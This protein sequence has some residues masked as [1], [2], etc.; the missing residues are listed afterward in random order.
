M[1]S[2][3]ISKPTCQKANVFH[4]E[5]CQK[6]WDRY[7]SGFTL[8]EIL[9]G[10]MIM[11]VVS[12]GVG[13]LA[14]EAVNQSSA[15]SN[16]VRDI[17]EAQKIS[18]SL[19]QLLTSAACVSGPAQI[20]GG[21]VGW[22]IP[23]VYDQDCGGD[24]SQIVVPLPGTSTPSPVGNTSFYLFSPEEIPV[25]TGTVP[26]SPALNIYTEFYVSTKAELV[27]GSNLVYVTVQNLQNGA[28]TFLGSDLRSIS[29]SYVPYSNIVSFS[30]KCSAGGSPIPN[31]GAI[32]GSIE[33]D[34]SMGSSASDKTGT[35]Y[36]SCIFLPGSI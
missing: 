6:V 17:S 30:N 21:G 16:R 2:S 24:P 36:E 3:I 19:D 13:K 25:N 4:Y 1:T 20:V 18:E 14:F 8:I 7:D 11:M 10:L 34:L 33:L 22:T 27:G 35:T 15:D 31:D 23:P 9:I 5:S 29:Y 28:V 12:V 32:T 26:V